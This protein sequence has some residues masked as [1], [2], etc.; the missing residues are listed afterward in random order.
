MPD[1][2]RRYAVLGLAAMLLP[3]ASAAALPATRSRPSSM[4]PVHPYS[5]NP[6]YGHPIYQWWR[7]RYPP[8]GG[9]TDR[10]SHNCSNGS[11]HW[12]FISP[13][14]RCGTSV[15][16]TSPTVNQ[17]S[18]ASNHPSSANNHNSS[19]AVPLAAAA[20]GI[21]ALGLGVQHARRRWRHKPPPSVSVTL[22][23]DAGHVRIVRHAPA[24]P[25]GGGSWPLAA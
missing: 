21:G 17:P 18:W 10:P 5:A 1:N 14:H 20:L 15:S 25:E 3:L 13:S 4:G 9:L 22:G 24:G 19:S 12:W 7:D 8:T 6:G 23:M 2:R 11:V 16:T